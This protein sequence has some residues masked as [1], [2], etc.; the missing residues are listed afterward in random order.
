MQVD[1]SVSI[2][3][4]GETSEGWVGKKSYVV[5]VGE[6]GAVIVTQSQEGLK[7]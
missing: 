7:E 5:G 1:A 3:G 6:V 4:E 2:K